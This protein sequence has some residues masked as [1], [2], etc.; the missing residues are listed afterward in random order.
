[1]EEFKDVLHSAKYCLE[2][3]GVNG[4]VTYHLSKWNSE[5]KEKYIGE[6]EVWNET[7]SSISGIF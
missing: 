7:E 3:L 5:N 6:P 4:D 2:T 1:M